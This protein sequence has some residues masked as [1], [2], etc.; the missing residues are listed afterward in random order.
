MER[1]ELDFI[2]V[3]HERVARLGEQQEVVWVAVDGRHPSLCAVMAGADVNDDGGVM[4]RAEGGLEGDPRVLRVSEV[5]VLCGVEG[6]AVLHAGDDLLP[7]PQPLL[8]CS[9]GTGWIQSFEAEVA[10]LRVGHAEHN[11]HSLIRKVF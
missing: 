4:G 1:T 3:E 8:K 10:G 5:E 11:N 2:D 7:L 6:E 9:H